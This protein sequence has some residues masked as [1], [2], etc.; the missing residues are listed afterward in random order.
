MT[1][2]II[3]GTKVKDFGEGTPFDWLSRPGLK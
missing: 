3:S 2:G 1:E